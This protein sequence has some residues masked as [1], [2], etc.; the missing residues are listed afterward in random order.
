M[1]DHVHRMISVP[2]KY[3]VSQVVGYIKGKSAIYLARTCGECQRNFAGQHFWARG[4]FVST[5]GRDEK[6]IREYIHNQDQQCAR[7]MMP[8]PLLPQIFGERPPHIPKITNR[9]ML[10]AARVGMPT[11]DFAMCR[12]K[13]FQY[14]PS[15][16]S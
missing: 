2:P 6:T 4:N 5:V 9:G 7:S 13:E 1:R 14:A 15:R 11:S 3:A 8:C 12:T 10:D 16:Q